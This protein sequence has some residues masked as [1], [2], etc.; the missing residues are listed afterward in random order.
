MHMSMRNESRRIR[1]MEGRE[2]FFYCNDAL[3]NW[4]IEVDH[5]ME[6]TS[7]FVRLPIVRCRCCSCRR[8]DVYDGE[9]K[10]IFI[11]REVSKRNKKKV[12]CSILIPTVGNFTSHN[13][14]SSFELFQPTD[15][16]R[17]ADCNCAIIKRKSDESHQ[18]KHSDRTQN[19]IVPNG[20]V[21][22]RRFECCVMRRVVC[23]MLPSDIKRLRLAGVGLPSSSQ[24]RHLYAFDVC[25]DMNEDRFQH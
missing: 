21:V 18:A 12:F 8:G 17:W 6:Q 15:N 25:V 10:S 23:F 5:C 1:K 11:K 14:Q 20:I 4:I 13:S 22:S 19:N 24:S 16:L 7:L 2:Y 3:S 9:Q